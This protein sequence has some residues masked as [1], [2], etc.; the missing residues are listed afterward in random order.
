MK[1]ARIKVAGEIRYAEV[2]GEGESFRLLAGDLFDER[3]VTDKE[4]AAA[5]ARLL[6]PV[7]PRQLVAIGLNYSKHAR[8][9]GMAAPK[10]PVLFVKT[11]NAIANPGEPILLP[12]MA[13]EEVDYEAELAIVI[14]KQAKH[15]AEADADNYI[16]GYTCA[17]DV[18][19]RDC[20]LREDVQWAR[21][22]CFDTFAPLGPWIETELDGD[23]LKIR[24]L[25]NGKVM[26]NSNTSDLI[27]SCRKILSYVSECMTLYPGSVI[28]TGT[29]EGVGM[30]RDPQV[31]LRDGDTVTIEIEG[32]GQLTNPVRSE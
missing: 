4:V 6:A 2:I 20:Q 25:L 27:F 13:P 32:I 3:R 28:M 14:G 26:Q 23:N 7:E 5:D 10:A 15:V 12:R 30:G 11:L 1:I 22:K 24:T 18:S 8:E 17:N 31:F 29:P 19:A 16:L 9:S 21:G